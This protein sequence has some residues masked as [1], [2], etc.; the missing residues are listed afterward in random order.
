MQSYQHFT[1]E[2]RES[3]RIMMERGESMRSAAKAL[4]RS[5]S[6]VSREMRRNSNKKTQE[7]NVWG[8][9]SLYLK[10][11]KRCRR[12]LRIT[13]DTELMRFA[14]ER[15]QKYW[16]P[17]TIAAKWN[18]ENKDAPVSHATIYKALKMGLIPK[19]SAKEHLRWHGRRKYVRGATTTIKPDRLL[20]Q[21]CTAANERLRIGDW[22]GDLVLGGVGKGCLLTC[23]DRRSRYLSV[24]VLKDKTAPHVREAFKK[25]LCEKTIY[26]LTLDNGPEF[27]A[28]RAIEAD[29]KAEIYFCDPHSPWQRGSNENLNGLLRFFYPKGT[30]FR[31]VSQ[32][33]ADAIVSLINERPRKCL[34]WLSP[35]EF[36]FAKCCT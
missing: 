24:R 26:T 29:L 33:E 16:P 5:P 27:S 35:A 31:C 4:G 25:A 11:R 21:R 18:Q 9:T 2:E 1:L 28:F 13:M 12:K 6:T 14:E 23:V 15:L 22:E 3:L 17:E 36:F 20:A 32:A 34:G 30:D 8:A 19:C 10:R 7:Y